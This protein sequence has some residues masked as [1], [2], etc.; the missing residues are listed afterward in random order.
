MRMAVSLDVIGGFAL[1]NSAERKKR[2]NFWP[3][4]VMTTCRYLYKFRILRIANDCVMD[5]D[6]LN[7]YSGISSQMND[8]RSFK[9]SHGE[10]S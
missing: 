10:Q 2:D 5:K 6:F 1:G 9:I 3:A 4:T 8:R 7:I